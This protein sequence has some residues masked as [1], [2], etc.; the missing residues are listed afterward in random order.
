MLQVLY[1]EI[2]KV[3]SI[4]F[5]EKKKYFTPRATEKK[6]EKV[7]KQG[8]QKITYNDGRY[9]GKYSNDLRSGHGTFY[10]NNNDKV[11]GTWEN[12]KMNGYGTYYFANGDKYEGFFKDGLFHGRGTLT[13][14]NGNKIFE[15]NLRVK[16]EIEKNIPKYTFWDIFKRF[17]EIW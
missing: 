14:K 10:F 4:H 6:E 8:W 5:Q 2:R 11:E 3:F 13:Y 7:I 17:F 15:T 9:E 12:D 1:L 16:N